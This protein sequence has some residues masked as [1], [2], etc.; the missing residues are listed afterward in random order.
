[1]RTV[2]HEVFHAYQ[3]YLAENIDWNS[4][5]TDSAYF[6]EALRWKKNGEDYLRGEGYYEQPLEVSARDYSDA[7]VLVYFSPG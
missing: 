5:V 3:D 6:D 1:M 7:A 4:A 2:A